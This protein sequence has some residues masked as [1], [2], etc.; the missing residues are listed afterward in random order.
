LANLH[1]TKKRNT[2]GRTFFLS[3]HWYI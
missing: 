3:R 2:S 1:S